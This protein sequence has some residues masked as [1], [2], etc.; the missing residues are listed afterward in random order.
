M[1]RPRRI[2]L[3]AVFF[4]TLLLPCT[5]ICLG[6]GQVQGTT[7]V[8]SATQHGPE[9]GRCHPSHATPQER[10]TACPACGSH[11]FLPPLPPG[12]A[13]G[14]APGPALAL[15]Y[16]YGPVLASARR[17]H[18]VS[19]ATPMRTAPRPRFLTLAVLRL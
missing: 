6:T 2:A 8:S 5:E 19:V 16:P 9:H 14:I 13:T 10:P 17:E 11:V 18:E 15:P 12:T 3:Y 7:L 1:H 4:L